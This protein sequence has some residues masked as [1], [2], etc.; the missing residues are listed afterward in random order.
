MRMKDEEMQV[1][2][3]ELMK[4]AIILEEQTRKLEAALKQEREDMSK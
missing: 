1:K 3:T 2:Y 4:K